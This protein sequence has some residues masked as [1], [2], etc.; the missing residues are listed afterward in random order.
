MAMIDILIFTAGFVILGIWSTVYKN[1]QMNRINRQYVDVVDDTFRSIS[2]W[3]LRIEKAIDAKEVKQV[4]NSTEVKNV[5][6]GTRRIFAMALQRGIET[7]IIIEPAESYYE[8]YDKVKAWG[9]GPDWLVIGWS[10]M[11]FRPEM[12]IGNQPAL[13]KTEEPAIQEDPIIK[14]GVN[15]YVVYLEYSRDNYAKTQVEKDAL[16]T[17]IKNIKKLHGS[18]NRQETSRSSNK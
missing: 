8:M 15:E 14:K 7:C 1:K 13:V 5:P 10:Y 9:Y 3:L 17:I 16:E 11:D 4:V 12:P 2:Q 6:Q 18:K